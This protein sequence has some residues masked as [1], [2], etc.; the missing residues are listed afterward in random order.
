MKITSLKIENFRNLHGLG[1]EFGKNIIAFV[2]EN[3]QGKT[4]ILEAIGVLAFGKSLR[5][6]EEK[7]LI[8]YGENYYR[9]ESEATQDNGEN[10]KI[11]VSAQLGKSFVKICKVNGRKI[12][13]SDLVGRLPVVSF[14]PEDLNLVLLSPGLRRRYLDILLSQMNRKYLQALSGYGKALKQRKIKNHSAFQSFKNNTAA[15]YFFY[16]HLNN[17]DF[18]RCLNSFH[19][20]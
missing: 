3:A 5:A 12:N 6:G 10:L 15:F 19:L 17:S 14:S 20:K 11:E 8:P 13:A 1:F 9:V 2:G 4:N 16:T 18:V 7:N